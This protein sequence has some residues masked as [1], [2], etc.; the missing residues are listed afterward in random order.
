MTSSGL[1]WS[2]TIDPWV[3]HMPAALRTLYR[4]HMLKTKA[5]SVIWS[6]S[7]LFWAIS[8]RCVCGKLWLV[9]DGLG[10]GQLNAQNHERWSLVSS[11]LRSSELFMSLKAFYWLNMIPFA[12][13]QLFKSPL[14]RTGTLPLYFYSGFTLKIEFGCLT[15]LVHI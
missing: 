11:L 5:A 9:F 1:P 10:L 2:Q 8:Q 15:W 7:E 4:Q 13:H 6:G 3:H 14:F 12:L